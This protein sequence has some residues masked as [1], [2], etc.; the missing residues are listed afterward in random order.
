MDDKL[1]RRKLLILTASDEVPGCETDLVKQVVEPFEID[2]THVQIFDPADLAQIPD[3]RFDYVYI[4]GHANKQTFGGSG[5]PTDRDVEIEWPGLSEAICTK[6]NQG[7]VVFLACCHGGLNQ[8]A[9]DLFIGCD[10]VETVVGSPSS[11]DSEDL[12]LAFHALIY[13]LE[14]RCDDPSI[15]VQRASV[16]TE[17]RFGHFERD[18]VEIDVNFLN[19]KNGGAYCVKYPNRCF[20]TH[21][22]LAPSEF[23]VPSVE[24]LVLT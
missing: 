19:Y 1:Q 13:G 7:A 20:G 17:K 10:S 5:K 9:F 11:V 3:S 15:A 14:F 16:V 12:R 2:V 22:E 24:S 21:V 6:L 18:Q 4:C 23:D 8:V